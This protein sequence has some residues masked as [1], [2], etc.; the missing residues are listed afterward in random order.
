MDAPVGS[1]V[2]LRLAPATEVTAQWK[3][4]RWSLHGRGAGAGAVLRSPRPTC[5][6][7]FPGWC[8]KAR[9]DPA[10]SVS[11][12]GS[13]LVTR[14]VPFIPLRPH[15]LFGAAQ[16]N[17]VMGCF[18]GYRKFLKLNDFS[19]LDSLHPRCWAWVETTPRRS[20]EAAWGGGSPLHPGLAFAQRPQA[21]L[22]HSSPPS[23]GC[24]QR[25]D[26]KRGGMLRE[27]KARGAGGPGSFLS[28]TGARGSK[29]N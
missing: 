28:K 25:P 20:G 29:E 11:T 23:P 4:G 3:T 27:E 2:C 22:S 26:Q 9:V 17:D 14:A 5:R 18:K 16:Q 12:H 6:P 13:V 21:C 7:G 1:H 24:G 10:V 8:P 15:L 19:L